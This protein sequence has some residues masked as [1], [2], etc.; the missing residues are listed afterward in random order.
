MAG[1]DPSLDPNSASFGQTKFYGV[2]RGRVPGVYTDWPSAQAQVVG[3][4][5]PKHRC[6][7]TRAEAETF[8]K[9][10]ESVDGSTEGPAAA[11]SAS[12]GDPTT[13]HFDTP[14]AG[15]A[16]SLGQGNEK[17]KKTRKSN[18]GGKASQDA[19]VGN[20]GLPIAFDEAISQQTFE[21]GTGPLPPDAEDDF[22]PMVAL[23]PHTG[24]LEWKSDVQRRKTIL[25]PTGPKADGILRIYTDGSSL[26]NGQ[27][28]AVGGIGVYF[29]DGDPRS[30][31][32]PLRS[33]C[34]RL[35]YM[36]LTCMSRT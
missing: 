19:A 14:S 33:L 23:N 21:P 1:N 26:K 9:E 15:L 12:K 10:A 30:V 35:L 11:A 25:Q 4:T 3:W 24:K 8:V 5:R 27:G 28:G 34:S 7:S 18:K 32:R 16:T 31:A 36:D 6:F 13:L 22:D 2:Q 17:Q 29:G 20:I